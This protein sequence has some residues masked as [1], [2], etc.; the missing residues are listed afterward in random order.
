MSDQTL[1]DDIT[2]RDDARQKATLAK[3]YD[4]VEGLLGSSLRYVHGSGTDEDRKLYLER[5]RGGYYD[6]TN[7]TALRREFRRFGD[8]ILVHGDMR[9]HVIVNGV[10]KDFNGRYLQVWALEAGDWKMVA[11]QTT[12]L[13][14]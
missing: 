5:L 2:A 6:Y 13:A 11:W 8:T 9:I 12:P 1:F 14:K 10:E 4:T 7:R 3:D